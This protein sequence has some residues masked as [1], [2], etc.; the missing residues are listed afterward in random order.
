[1]IQEE[2]KNKIL[3]FSLLMNSNPEDDSKGVTVTFIVI[4]FTF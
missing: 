3:I 1:M 2:A 4:F